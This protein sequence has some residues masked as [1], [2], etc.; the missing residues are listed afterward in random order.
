MVP[1]RRAGERIA[2]RRGVAAQTTMGR[3]R[4]RAAMVPMRRAGERIAMRRGVAAQTTMGRFRGP[5][6]FTIIANR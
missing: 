6:A 5:S 2:M 1:M 3:L 4:G